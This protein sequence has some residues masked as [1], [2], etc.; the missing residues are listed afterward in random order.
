MINRGFSGYNTRFCKL[1]LPKLITAS[2]S[3]NTQL[4]TIL[5]GANDSVDSVKCT[6]QHVPLEEFKQNLLDM[7]GYLESIGI[8]HQKIILISPPACDEK[9]WE[10]DCEKNGRV[11]GK[12]NEPT[13]QY[14]QACCD[15]SREAGT[16]SVDFF[17]AMISQKNW[18]QMLNDGLHLSTE[19]SEFLFDLLKPVIDKHTKH[20]PMKYPYWADIDNSNPSEELNK[21]F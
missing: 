11:F 13:R 15:V 18:G 19:G 17:S 7:V 1:I 8:P 9:K 5:L 14:A 20:L 6:K 2:D 16:E 4:V 12:Y 21:Y 10:K 3:L